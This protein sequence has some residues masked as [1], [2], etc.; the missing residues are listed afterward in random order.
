MKH[1]PHL[2]VSVKNFSRREALRAFA[3]AAGSVPFLGLVSACGGLS[4]SHERAFRQPGLRAYAEKRGRL[5]GVA[6]QSGQLRDRAFARALADEANAL[7]P[8][9]ELKWDSLRPSRERFDFEGFEAL[10]A[11]AD[12]HGMAMR[13]HALVW[14]ESN[15]PWL[16]DS[17]RKAS[18][19]EAEQILREHVARVVQATRSHISEWDVVNEALDPRSSRGDGLRETLW[20]RA[21]GPDYVALAFRAACEADSGLKLVYNDYGLERGDGYGEAKRKAALGLM[22]KL[23][24]EGVPIHGLGLQSHLRVDRPL[25]GRAFVDFLRQARGFGFEVSVT[26]LDLRYGNLSGDIEEKDAFA[27][28]YLRSY[29]EL[30]QR[31]APLKSLL[32]WGLSDRYSWLRQD[33][34]AARGM[35]PLDVNLDRAAMWETLR[36]GWLA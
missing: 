33:D 13:G 11:F 15:P 3:Q 4:I 8:E 17:L 20:L 10:A 26:E 31:D 7:V 21:L 35:L 24:V 6:A 23:R 12:V 14:H 22:D 34:D 1:R 32:T 36:E 30:V 27:Q 28:D 19:S 18:R 2:S 9:N 25:G 16:G 29:L 5:F